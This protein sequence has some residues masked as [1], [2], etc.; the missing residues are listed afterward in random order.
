MI[1]LH[2]YKID[3]RVIMRLFELVQAFCIMLSLLRLHSQFILF[4]VG[5]FLKETRARD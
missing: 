2:I 3:T 4:E 1:F 5:K